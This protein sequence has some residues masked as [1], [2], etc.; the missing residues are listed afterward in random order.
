MLKTKNMLQIISDGKINSNK[1]KKGLEKIC[2]L[3]PKVAEVFDV[4]DRIYLIS[5]ERKYHQLMNSILDNQSVS[6][7]FKETFFRIYPFS[8]MEGCEVY[9]FSFVEQRIIVINVH[10]ILQL[11]NEYKKYFSGDSYSK[12]RDYRYYAELCHYDDF[13][14]YMRNDQEIFDFLFWNTLL[15]EIRRAQQSIQSGEVCQF[16][17]PEDD[18]ICFAKYWYKKLF[19]KNEKELF[20]EKVEQMKRMN[21]IELAS[22]LEYALKNNTL[23]KDMNVYDFLMGNF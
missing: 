3:D 8:R 18:L 17:Y 20:E 13:Y 2:S 15:Q 12:R 19:Y 6:E 9:R 11:A 21:V 22:I 14:E 7:S 4:I 16:K 5:T 1:V 10:Q 23:D